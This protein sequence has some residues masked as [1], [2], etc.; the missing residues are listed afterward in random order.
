MINSLARRFFVLPLLLKIIWTFCVMGA[1]LNIVL[2]W[3]DLQGNFV[4]FRLHAGFFVL[5]AAQVVFILLR[6]RLVFVLSLL[7]ALLAFLSN[8]DFTFVPLGRIVGYSVYGFYG[9]FTVEAMEVYKYV[10]VSFC[11]TLELLKT[12]LLFALL[13]APKKKKKIVESSQA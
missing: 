10:F 11:F 8:F 3:R 7:Q 1:L 6:E 2:M 12:W 9:G 13:P 5:Y 4:L